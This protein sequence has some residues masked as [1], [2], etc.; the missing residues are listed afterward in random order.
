MRNKISSSWYNSLV[1]PGLKGRFLTSVYFKIARTGQITD[2]K[3]EKT[4]G[5]ST[6]DLSARRA[7][8]N[9]A[10]FA[11]LPADFPYPLL[12]VHFEFEWEKK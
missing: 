1:S 3:V 11:A 7:V 9:A 6:L 12:I 8:E 2:V 10:P 4:S 5:I